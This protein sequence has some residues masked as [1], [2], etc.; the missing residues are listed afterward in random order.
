M[1]NA[2][3][4][5]QKR[6]PLNG[7]G[8]FVYIPKGDEVTFIRAGI[9]CQVSVHGAGWIR[10]KVITSSTDFLGLVHGVNWRNVPDS[11]GGNQRGSVCTYLRVLNKFYILPD[12]LGA[13]ILFKYS[14]ADIQAFS[15]DMAALIE[16][17]KEFGATPTKNINYLIELVATGNGGFNQSSYLD[18]DALE[19]FSY[20]ECQGNAIRHNFYSSREE[21]Y[22]PTSNQKHMLERTRDEILGNARAVLKVEGK[23]TVAH[24]TGG[25]DSR[26]VLAA[27]MSA[28]MDK[29]AMKFMCSGNI[30]LPDKFIST[31]LCGHLG[32]AMT[33]SVGT[34]AQPFEAGESLFST[35]GL[36]KFD[37]P[38][39][40]LPNH[41]LLSGGYGECFRSFYGY[42]VEFPEGASIADTLHKIHGSVF[43]PDGERLISESFYEDYKLKFEQFV[44]DARGKGI[45]QDAILD[46]MYITMRSRYFFGL[47]AEYQSN[48]S[49]RID[50]L[51]SLSGMKAAMNLPL[52]ERV[53]NVIGLEL[54]HSYQ[55]ELLALPFDYDRITIEYEAMYGKVDRMAFNG[56][57]P[58][59][60]N[61]L[62]AN[63]I[64][65]LPRPTQEQI[66]KAQ[67]L[68]VAL[69]QIIYMER[70][71]K[72]IQ[73]FISSGNRR[74]IA[75]VFNLK[76]VNRLAT[77]ELNNRVHLRNLY[78][79]YDVLKWYCVQN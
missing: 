44:A 67:T 56:K 72:Q 36:L 19:Q 54:M 24:L 64:Q 21:F 53:A 37:P 1:K 45:R 8:N 40:A 77:R 26:L 23:S 70:V 28:G 79:I 74:T 59:V 57:Q 5:I 12:P 55:N 39:A 30:E 49:P 14:C 42:R 2:P 4:L 43:A 32:I 33:N 7:W 63:D 52:N 6:D 65:T 68:K 10:D 78:T 60:F 22:T 66:K 71:Q 13:A 61:E 31:Q 50:P 15:T 73:E 27:L 29:S 16:V 58:E 20:I 62:V 3:V 48:I 34:L 11:I 18:V 75:N 9:E 69:W 46:Y 17:V 25:F 35:S 38:K 51:Y 47:I 76:F 41:L